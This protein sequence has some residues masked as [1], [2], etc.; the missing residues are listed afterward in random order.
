MFRKRRKK[1]AVIKVFG[2]ITAIG[3]VSV[4][5]YTFFGVKTYALSADSGA[6]STVITNKE[7]ALTPPEIS[8][9]AAV[10][11]DAKTGQIVYGKNEN[12]RLPMASTTKIMTTLLMLES[13]GLETEFV[14]GP[15]ILVE[16]SSMGL[17]EGDLVSKLDLCYGMM[18]PSGNDAANATAYILGGGTAGFSELMNRKAATLG[19]INSHFITPSGLHAANHYSTASDMAIL[20]R[21]ALEN[22]DF[23][24]IAATESIKLEYG[25][26]PY[27]R[28]LSNSNKL[29][30]LYDGC[31][32]VKTGFTD[33]AGRCL[34][35][36]AERGGVKL[37]C[38]TLDAPND[39][40]DHT[41]LLNYGFEAV[42]AVEAEF[43]APEDFAID[44]V[45]GD[46]DEVPLSLERKPIFMS[47][48]GE[49]PE[50]DCSI[51]LPEFI[52]APV[53]AGQTVGRAEFIYDG[54]VVDEV[55]I[56]AGEN[57]EKI[58][59]KQPKALYYVIIDFL[60]KY[61]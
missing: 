36:A 14:M 16:G 12:E 8:A 46:A 34:I 26:P 24:K 10:L 33:E 53:T 13:G 32:G 59:R 9:K 54:N 18:L 55:S 1:N 30:S 47:V 49:I 25:N 28:W 40:A 31:I 15:E 27:K 35:S 4:L 22:P 23:A 3:V 45:G 56:I 44:V 60:K 17:L 39:W 42:K 50:F 21:A 43:N 48:K 2:I 58:T 41:K 29:L 51:I 38:C 61:V 57:V 7:D 5:M 52:Y 20:T 19:M 37:I 6:L 11:I